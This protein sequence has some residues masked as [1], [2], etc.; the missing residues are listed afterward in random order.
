MYARYYKGY[1]NKVIIVNGNNLPSVYGLRSPFLI[2]SS[3]SIGFLA[4]A[5]HNLG[6][7]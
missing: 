7:I 3:I 4:I 1:E 5:S 6:Q 2:K